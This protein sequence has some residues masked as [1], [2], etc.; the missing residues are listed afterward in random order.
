MSRLSRREFLKRSGALAG[1]A[2]LRF[3]SAAPPAGALAGRALTVADVHSHADSSSPVLRQLAP[4]SVVP[5]AGLSR[6][7]EWYQIQDSFVRRELLQP[8]LPYNRPDVI[9]EI[10]V[11]FW[12]EV[13]VPV[14]PIR[15]WCAGAAP[16]LARPGFGAVVYIMDRLVDDHGMAWYGIAD[17]PG[18]RLVGWAP[19][20]HY[21]PWTTASKVA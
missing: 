14:S 10:G 4:D 3:D 20:L 17:A 18:A 12:A 11:G 16:I 6:D 21:T 19:A 5:I 2:T 13:I 1:A 8:I 7:T 15:E 9:A